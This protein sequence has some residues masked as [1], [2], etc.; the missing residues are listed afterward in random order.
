MT[1]QMQQIIQID[2]LQQLSQA[3]LQILTAIGSRKVVALYGA[4]GVGKT[5][6]VKALCHHL[7]VS[8]QVNSPTFTLVNEYKAANGRFVWHFDFYRITKIEEAYDLG[9]DEYFEGDGL[10]LIEWPQLIEELL[11]LDVARIYLR[12]LANGV[13]EVEIQ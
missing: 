7:G 10:C 8:D 3:A 1:I 11:P 12:E 9:Y 4:M 5:T 2:S 6:L 13:R